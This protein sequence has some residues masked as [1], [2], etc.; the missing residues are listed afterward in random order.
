M[1]TA[2]ELFLENVALTS[3]ADITQTDTKGAMMQDGKGDAVTLITLHASKGLEYPVV[4]IVGLEEGSLPH[5]HAIDKPEQLEEERR[6]AYVGFT[7]AMR[8]LYLVHAMRRSFFGEHRDTEP[9]RFLDDVPA[10]LIV[11][12]QMGGLA[13]RGK[14]HTSKVGGILWAPSTV[15]DTE[16]DHTSRRRKEE[17]HPSKQT[18]LLSVLS[19][20]RSD[21][22]DHPRQAV[23]WPLASQVSSSGSFFCT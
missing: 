23:T 7:R 11:P 13:I 20:E 14:Q 12:H 21:L 9:S 3:G 17:A 4:F 18:P 10:D 6:L 5:A 15:P 2:L 19:H 22:A 8:R 1:W 16:H